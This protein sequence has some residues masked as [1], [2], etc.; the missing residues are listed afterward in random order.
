LDD[1]P[2]HNTYTQL[3]GWYI[4]SRLFVAVHYAFTGLLLPLIRGNMI[5]QAILIVIPTALWIASIHVEMPS[6]LGLIFTAIVADLF[7]SMVMVGLFRYARFHQTHF[8]IWL[9]KWFDFFP[10]HNIEH[11]VE[12]TNAFVSL[13][14]GYSVVGVLFQNQGF[15]LNAILGKAIL[16]LIQAFIFNWLYFEV[17]GANIHVH[18]IR[19]KVE[20]GELLRCAATGNGDMMVG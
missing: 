3:V 20:T 18:A 15:G 5:S 6:R 11:K 17:D 12:R 14:F 7:G 10:A 8:A 19:R 9:M 1:D 13:V 4:A 2:E 16:G